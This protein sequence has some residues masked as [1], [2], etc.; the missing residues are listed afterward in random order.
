MLS[1]RLVAKL[2]SVNATIT[3]TP[4]LQNDEAHNRL[5]QA[6]HCSHSDDVRL[7]ILNVPS[8]AV[9]PNVL[10]D[11]DDVATGVDGNGMSAGDDCAPPWPGDVG[12]S[13]RG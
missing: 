10:N 11:V 13:T 8:G 6:V 1:R 3:V 5:V 12:S 9:S 2:E 7:L 4:S